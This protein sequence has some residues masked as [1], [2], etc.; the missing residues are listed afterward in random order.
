MGLR[1][2]PTILFSFTRPPF[3]KRWIALPTTIQRT[4]VR[5]TNCAM[6]WIVIFSMDCVSHLLNNWG[7]INLYPVDSAISL[8]LLDSAIQR[9][10]DRG[11]IQ[12]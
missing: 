4:S 11:Q 5:E 9:L 12:Y 1:V 7:Q 2:W 8:I 10:S 3:F 6:Q